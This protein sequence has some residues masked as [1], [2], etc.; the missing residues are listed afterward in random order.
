LLRAI[1][2]G[3]SRWHSLSQ[4]ARKAAEKYFSLDATLNS[5]ATLYDRAIQEG[6]LTHRRVPDSRD[7]L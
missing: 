7:A 4:N 5:Y 6:P 2:E 1:D 3:M